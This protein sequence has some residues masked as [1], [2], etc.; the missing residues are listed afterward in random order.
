M[1]LTAEPN[2]K[3]SYELNWGAGGQQQL[4]GCGAKAPVLLK[5]ANF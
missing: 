1:W 3:A 2:S 4:V 5:S